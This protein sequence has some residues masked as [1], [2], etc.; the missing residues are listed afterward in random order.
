MKAR[1]VLSLF[2]V[3][4]LIVANALHYFVNVDSLAAVTAVITWSLVPLLLFL[5]ICKNYT[6]LGSIAT[7]ALSSIWVYI[8]FCTNKGGYYSDKTMFIAIGSVSIV[9]IILQFFAFLGE[10]MDPSFPS[11]EEFK[12]DLT[13]IK[14]VQKDSNKN[15]TDQIHSLNKQVSELKDYQEK[16][17]CAQKA[18]FS[19]NNLKAAIK[20]DDVP[21]DIIE[22]FYE[23]S[24]INVET[25]IHS[26]CIENY[27]ENMEKRL[28]KYLK[29]LNYRK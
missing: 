25:H 20:S 16:M 22:A 26:V 14:N 2:A 6:V 10:L 21:N 12:A 1:N 11:F 19:I 27:D 18:G 7:I 4:L 9:A 23:T 8:G 28:L 15:T 17:I 5:A 24:A 3:I 13:K 29:T